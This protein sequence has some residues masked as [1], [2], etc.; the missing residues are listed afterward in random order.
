MKTIIGTKICKHICAALSLVMLCGVPFAGTAYS[1]E[2]ELKTQQT[3]EVKPTSPDVSGDT[4]KF[5]DTKD[6]TAL[7]TLGK[8]DDRL[9]EI[10]EKAG[11]DELI[12]VSIWINDIDFEEVEK[13]VEAEV[14]L[15]RNILEQKSDALRNDFVTSVSARLYS[16]NA[17]A[18]MSDN[19]F[20]A[21]FK[22]YKEL[23]K[24]KVERFDDDVQSYTNV[25]RNTAKEM[26]VKSNEEFVD[27]FLRDA[28]DVCV[29]EFFPIID[30][31]ITKDQI[32]HSASLSAVQSISSNADK[33][34]IYPK[35]LIAESMEGVD[36]TTNEADK[37]SASYTI[38]NE[39]QVANAIS[40]N[41]KAVDGYYTRDS[42]GFDGGKIKI[43]Q[44][45]V[46]MPDPSVNQ[47][48]N[49]TIERHGRID[50]DDHATLVASI[51]VGKDGMS[52]GAKLYCTTFGGTISSLRNCVNTLIGDGVNIINMS[53]RTGDDAYLT[54]NDAAKLAD[55]VVYNY[56]ITWVKSAGNRG[57]EDGSGDVRVTSPGTAY[58]V[59][60]VGAIDTRADLNASNDVYGWY[61]SYITQEGS[62][63][64]PEVVA[65]GSNY[66]YVG[67]TESVFGTSFSAPVVAG[68]A[69]QLM[70]FSSE[71]IY[72]PEAIKAAIIASCDHKTT[73]ITGTAHISAKEGA[74]VV[75]ALNAVNSLSLMKLQ[76]TYYNTSESSK[77]FTLYPITDGKKS[78]AISW[79]KKN[80]GTLTNPVEGPLA[81]F[82]LYVYYSDTGHYPSASSTNGYEYVSFDASKSKTYKIHIE[83]K[84]SSVTNERIALAINR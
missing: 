15:S 3:D 58:N 68:L 44:I 42:L 18:D 35:Q 34:T 79:L 37:M 23:N 51:M 40:T 74:G 33:D 72:K 25:Q 53:C 78:V 39:S 52:P 21:T 84:G 30:C 82:N 10:L 55:Y 47:L 60:T 24:A 28:K 63:A 43:G 49:S 67:K 2:T 7:K 32:L 4:D 19:D 36:L 66:Y 8:I 56:N 76:N 59:I 9:C 50:Y 11:D 22:D 5:V 71:M 20:I 57:K 70:S 75:D 14:G 80:A 6:L 12:P 64:K 46:G 54:Y 31:S 38:N 29:Y 83:K 48:K 45:D 81:N 62:Y 27:E 17:V 41:I 26:L 13:K 61:S 16:A 65:P 73:D 1:V 77:D 69:A